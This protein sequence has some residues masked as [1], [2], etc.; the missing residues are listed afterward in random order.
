MMSV[1]SGLQK[2]VSQTTIWF[3]LQFKTSNA[4][5]KVGSAENAYFD[6][7]TVMQHTATKSLIEFVILLVPLG[8]CPLSKGR[9]KPRPDRAARGSP[10]QGPG[11]MDCGR[12]RTTP[13]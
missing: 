9:I 2:S 13:S 1:V 5:L 8:P 7:T 4:P 12:K 6:D 10:S 3:T 11:R